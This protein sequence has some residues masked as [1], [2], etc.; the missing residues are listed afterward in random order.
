[1]PSSLQ[2]WIDRVLSKL[3]INTAKLL[4]ILFGII[5]EDFMNLDTTKRKL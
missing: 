4:K 2:D 3:E 1:M 5:K